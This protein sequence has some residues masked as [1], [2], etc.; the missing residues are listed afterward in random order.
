MTLAPLQ[1][2]DYWVSFI[3]VRANDQFQLGEN[4]VLDNDYLSIE[5]EVTANEGDQSEENGTFWVVGL[6]IEQEIPDGENIPYAFTL[7]ISGLVAAHPSMTGEKLER[8]IQVN[9]PSLLFG[10]AREILRAA[11]GRGPFP[12]VIIPSTN[13]FQRL[14]EPKEAAKPETIEM[15]AKENATPTKKPRKEAAPRSTKS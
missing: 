1:L 10:A 14:P 13:F 2:L 7:E 6:R 3:Q 15:S 5:A 12:P 9:G 8:A 4:T 11:T